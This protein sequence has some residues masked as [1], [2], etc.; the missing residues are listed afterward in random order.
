MK[1]SRQ[2]KYELGTIVW[3]KP[4]LKTFSMERPFTSIDVRISKRLHAELRLKSGQN[5]N[6]SGD[7]YR[8]LTNLIV[9]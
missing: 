3:F 2:V 1:G 6:L 7:L 8:D 5:I 9:Y 4:C